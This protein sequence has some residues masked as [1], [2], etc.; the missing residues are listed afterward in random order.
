[1]TYDE[2]WTWSRSN[3]SIT[4]K[5]F[6]K[7]KEKHSTQHQL[8]VWP[9]LRPLCEAKSFMVYKGCLFRCKEEYNEIYVFKE[10]AVFSL[11]CGISVLVLSLP[12]IKWLKK[13]A[14]AQG[15]FAADEVLGNGAGGGASSSRQDNSGESGNFGDISGDSNTVTNTVS[16]SNNATGNVQATDSYNTTTVNNYYTIYNN[17]SE[18]KCNHQIEPQPVDSSG[19]A[20]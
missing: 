2:F 8:C 16:D 15:W 7:E 11:G 17:Y 3:D 19:Q 12:L 9:I 5:E 10:S 13:K 20:G 18:C 6:L 1:M 14:T 4:Y